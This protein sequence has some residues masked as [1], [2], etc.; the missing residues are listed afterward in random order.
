MAHKIVDFWLILIQHMT[1][2]LQPWK[3]SDDQVTGL[4]DAQYTATETLWNVAHLH[5]V[6]AANGLQISMPTQ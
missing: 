4:V 6:A 2:N 5:R 1:P 3:V